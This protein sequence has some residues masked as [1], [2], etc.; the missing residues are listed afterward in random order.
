MT[1]ANVSSKGDDRS[2]HQSGEARR[3]QVA[4]LADRGLAG[5]YSQSAQKATARTASRALHGDS[6]LSNSSGPN[7]GQ[8]SVLS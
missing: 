1:T 3:I 4:A 2:V 7:N 6:C 8:E 5:S